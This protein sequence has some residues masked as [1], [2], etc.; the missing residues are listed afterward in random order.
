[1]LWNCVLGMRLGQRSGFNDLVADQTEPPFPALEIN[2]GFEQIVF[3]KLRP[4]H[5]GVMQFGVGHLV[6]EKIADSFFAAGANQ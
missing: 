3:R 2:D 4:Q 6:Q 5:L 1:M